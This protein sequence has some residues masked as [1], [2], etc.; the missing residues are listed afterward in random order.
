MKPM[1][2]GVTAL[3]FAALL[4]GAAVL[5]L[6]GN[7]VYPGLLNLPPAHAAKIRTQQALVDDVRQHMGSYLET[8]HVRYGRS[9]TVPTYFGDFKLKGIPLT[10]YFQPGAWELERHGLT[11]SAL[12]NNERI[13]GTSRFVTLARTFA[14]DF[15]RQHTMYY[16]DLDYPGEQLPPVV[17]RKMPKS[18]GPVVVVYDHNDYWDSS[19][20]AQSLGVYAWD[21]EENGWDLVHRGE[22]PECR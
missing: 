10:F 1:R 4:V 9:R 7:Q 3:V 2:R 17:R 20:Q 19:G 22:I 13:G 21:P 5:W 8:V 15:P 11:P 6:V 18:A 16:W 12:V 14:R